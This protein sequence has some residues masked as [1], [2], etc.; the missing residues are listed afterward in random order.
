MNNQTN[1]TIPIEL[2]NEVIAYIEECEVGFEDIRRECRTL[3]ELIEQN[4]MPECYNKL[5]K[6]KNCI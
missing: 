2:F 6:V 5:I 3:K 1:I 4:A